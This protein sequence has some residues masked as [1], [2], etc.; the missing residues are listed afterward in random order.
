[1]VKLRTVLTSCEHHVRFN[2]EERSRGKGIYRLLTTYIIH[3]CS[4]F[5]YLFIYLFAKWICNN[6]WKMRSRK[7]YSKMQ[8]NELTIKNEFQTFILELDNL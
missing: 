1:M 3:L 6:Y 7:N 8:T 2:V 4:L 5:I